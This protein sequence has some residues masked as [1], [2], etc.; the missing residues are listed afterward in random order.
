MNSA[1]VNMLHQQQFISDEEQAALNKQNLQPVSLFADLHVVLYA[2]VLLLSTGLGI[3]IYENIDNI[4][5][6][7]VVAIIALLC[8]GCFYWCFTHSPGFSAAKTNAGNNFTDYI[9]LLGCLLLLTLTGYLQYQYNLFGERWGLATFIPMILLFAAAYYFDHLGVLSIAITTLAAWAGITIA[10][11]R[12]FKN[13]FGNDHLIFTGIALGLLLYVAG[14]ASENK[15]FK[16]HFCFTYKNFAVH[17]LM[18]S[19]LAGMFHYDNTSLIWIAAIAVVA[20]YL[21]KQSFKE[22]SFYFFVITSLYAYIA[23][24]YLT[25]L[26]LDYVQ[27]DGGFYLYFMWII[28]SGVGFIILLINMNRIMKTAKP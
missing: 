11:T 27:N 19:L 24:C 7:V 2:G 12:I 28:G 9:L 4:G 15:K 14:I 1:F 10:P 17:L 8:T 21:L 16:T 18:I 26:P 13:D 6:G 3:L 25:Y 23:L 20:A 5:H 22:K